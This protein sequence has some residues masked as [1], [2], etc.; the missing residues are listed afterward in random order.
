MCKVDSDRARTE[1]ATKEGCMSEGVLGVDIAKKKFD[2][3]LL[4]KDKLKHKVFTN[5]QEGFMELSS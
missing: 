1:S 2:A 3:A 4:L 5:T